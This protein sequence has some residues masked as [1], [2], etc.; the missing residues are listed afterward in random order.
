MK[1][2]TATESDDEE[3]VKRVVP[4][5]KDMAKNAGWIEDRFYERDE[6]TGYGV[7]VLHAE[8]NL[9]VIMVCWPPGQDV[10]PHDHQTWAVVA[11][12]AVV[13]GAASGQHLT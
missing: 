5:T 12:S 11:G 1:S 3:I 2:I 9:Y 8:E 7:T 10:T 13:D 4:L 6:K